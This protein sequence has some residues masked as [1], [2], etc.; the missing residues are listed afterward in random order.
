LTFYLPPFTADVT[1]VSVSKAPYLWNYLFG[2]L[3]LVI[4]GVCLTDHVWDQDDDDDTT[5]R[6]PGN[7]AIAIGVILL[8]IF[9][10]Y[11]YYPM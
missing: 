2:G 10:Y 9:A 11:A 3:F 5:F 6:T 1:S 4:L 7:I 8:L